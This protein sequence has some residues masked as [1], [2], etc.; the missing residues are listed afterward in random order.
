[1]A[2]W[3]RIKLIPFDVVIP[4]QDRDSDLPRK[5]NAELPGILAWAVRGCLEWQKAGLAAPA[6][7]EAA[8]QSY[9]DAMD[10]LGEFIAERC[11]IGPN[12]S[13]SATKLYEQYKEWAEASGE[14]K[15]TQTNFGLRIAER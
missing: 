1:M 11:T 10:V 14:R 13:V 3:R 2:I 4:E 15:L 12:V 6:E 8:T 9:R 5:L 7:V